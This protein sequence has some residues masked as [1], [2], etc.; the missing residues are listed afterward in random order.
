M[1]DTTSS[2]IDTIQ[3]ALDG[4]CE[5]YTLRRHKYETEAIEGCQEARQDW[6]KYIG[7][8]ERFGSWNPIN[9]NLAAVLVPCSN[10]ERLRTVAYVFE[11][12]LSLARMRFFL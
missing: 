2:V 7:L 5:G 3:Y 8:I 6:M 4:F 9:G 11:C 1:D 12:M 10:P